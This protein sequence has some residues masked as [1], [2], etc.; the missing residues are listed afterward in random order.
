MNSCDPTANGFQMTE[1]YEVGPGGEE[2][3]MFDGHNNWQRTNVYGAGKLL[4]TYDLVAQAPALHF[5]LDDPRPPGSPATGLRRWGG[6]GS[7]RMQLAGNLAGNSSGLAPAGQ[8][9]T[10]IQSL[11]FG[12]QLY[13]FPDQYAPEPQTTPHPSTSPAKNE[14]PNQETTTSVPDTMRLRW[15]GL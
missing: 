1:S 8:P 4:A 9:E 6:F 13:S 3:A 7:R 12:D 15:G 11:P 10:D 2:L 5:H 14:I